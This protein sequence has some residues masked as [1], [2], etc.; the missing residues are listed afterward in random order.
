[1]SSPIR[2]FFAQFILP[3]WRL[4]LGLL[5]VMLLSTALAFPIP[6]LFR[7]IIDELI[8][9]G[10]FAELVWIG[11]ALVLVVALQGLFAYLEQYL[12]VVSEE[13]L[14]A[15]VE[16]TLVRHLLT[17]P[18]A[19][20]QEREVGYLMA[21]V[22]SDPVVA[23]D[24]FR[25]VLSLINNAV[26]LIGGAGLLFWLDWKLALVAVV[27][28]PALAL[29][30][31]DLNRRLQALCQEIQEG[32]ALL[33]RELGEGLSSVLTTK[34][35]RLS[36]W[37][38]GKIAQAIERLKEANVRTN[39]M[40]ALAGGVLTF[41]VRVGPVLLLCLG[42]WRIMRGDLSLGT[43]IA[44]VSFIG[45][46]YGPAQAIVTT[47]LGLQRAR[48]AARRILEIL[49]EVPEPS[50]KGALLVRS[51]QVEVD[52]VS[53]TYPNGTVA[54][55]DVSLLVEPGTWVAL[56]G[57]TG[58]GKSTLLSLLVR[59]YKPSSGTIRIDGQDL[60]VVDLTSLRKEVVLVTQDVFLFST[61]I[62]ENLRCGDPT[63]S[64]EEILR[65]TKALGAH[66]FIAELPSGYE[67][68]IGE[69]GVKLSGGQK[70]LLALARAVLRRPQILLL[71]EATS[72]MDSETEARALRA[73]AELMKGKTVIVAAHRLATVQFADRIF[74]LKDGQ[75][76]EVGT[77]EELI[78]KSG[79]YRA[80][81]EE[82]LVAAEG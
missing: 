75:V 45:Y 54:L 23:K 73:L 31:R 66:E 60:E 53:F 7:L 37:V 62:M 50:G 36:S 82:Q 32:D 76:V 43:V 78:R 59:L 30:S 70:Q 34:L 4:G 71:D 46:L 80:I 9:Q 6:I 52:R 41:I 64:E 22:R 29:S 5:C 19:F 25:G 26:F 40:G 39:T 57:R 44:F 49:D 42:A 18:P 79:E 63:I 12:T 65:V 3:R 35:L 24:F 68:P 47:N 61:T 38:E 74:V 48:V 81:F 16:N 77:H 14:V 8:P 51:G 10:R 1:M 56:V 15:D 21:R 55:R 13:T 67:T 28:L 58:S 33:S 69:R 27:V 17:L 2:R 11:L 20:F 72:A